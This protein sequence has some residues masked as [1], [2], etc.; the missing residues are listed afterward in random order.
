MFY[1]KSWQVYLLQSEAAKDLLSFIREY[2]RHE[3]VSSTDNIKDDNKTIQITKLSLSSKK[4][5]L[6]PR[7]QPKT[8]PGKAQPLPSSQVNEK[9][10]LDWK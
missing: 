9:R 5:P 8:G 6:F 3:A 7:G 4:S 10:P 2:F 1:I